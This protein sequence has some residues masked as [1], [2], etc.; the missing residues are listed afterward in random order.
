MRTTEERVKLIQNRTAELKKQ[1]VQKQKVQKQRTAAEAL[2]MAASLLL[3]VGIGFLMPE[4]ISTFQI[5]TIEHASGAASLI[6]TTDTL[7][8]IM[9]GLLCFL[10]GIVVTVLLYQLRRSQDEKAQKENEDEF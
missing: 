3:I 8:Y 5:N 2:C 9:M 7:G 4:V 10:L 6:G 1:K